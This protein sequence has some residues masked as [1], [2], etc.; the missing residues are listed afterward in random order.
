VIFIFPAIF[1][2]LVGP[3]AITMVNEMFPAMRVNK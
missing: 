3:A 1:I 2:V